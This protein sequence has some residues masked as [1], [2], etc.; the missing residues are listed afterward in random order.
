MQNATLHKMFYFLVQLIYFANKDMTYGS[1]HTEERL[2]LKNI[3]HCQIPPSSIGTLG[4][5]I[6]L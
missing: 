3:L 5:L 1:V 6:I 2:T 4:K